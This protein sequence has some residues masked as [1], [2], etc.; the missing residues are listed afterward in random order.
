[1]K[2]EASS[3]SYFWL[4]NNI[5]KFPSYNVCIQHFFGII[6]QGVNDELPWNSQGISSDMHVNTKGIHRDLC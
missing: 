4:P 5:P 3:D 1:M 2:A 6:K